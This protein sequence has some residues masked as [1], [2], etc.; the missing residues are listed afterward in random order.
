MLRQWMYSGRQVR[1]PTVR[2]SPPSRGSLPAP[3]I[4]NIVLFLF[5]LRCFPKLGILR[6]T[7]STTRPRGASKVIARLNNLAEVRISDSSDLRKRRGALPKPLLDEQLLSKKSLRQGKRKRHANKNK[8]HV[9]SPPL[10]P[11][12]LFYAA[13][14]TPSLSVCLLPPCLFHPCPC[15]SLSSSLAVKVPRLAKDSFIISEK[16]RLQIVARPPT[17]ESGLRSLFPGFTIGC[18]ALF[19]MCCIGRWSDGEGGERRGL[20]GNV[21]KSLQSHWRHAMM[22]AFLSSGVLFQIS[23][24]YQMKDWIIVF[25]GGRGNE[26]LCC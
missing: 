12:E 3:P 16:K 5:M 22:G 15:P 2:C 10:V 20:D 17:A 1:R 21:L 18:V 7:R 6:R 13:L 24:A 26:T 11:Q 8:N 19:L 4:T 14:P 23:L 25:V 9:L